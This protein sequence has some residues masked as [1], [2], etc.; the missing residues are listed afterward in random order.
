[1][2]A[3]SKLFTPSGRKFYVLFEEIADNINAVSRSF[4]ELTNTEGKDARKTLLDKIEQLEQD[5]DVVTHKLFVELGKNFI[6]PFDREDIH[7][8]ASALDDIADYV[9]GTA[10][11]MYYFEIHLINDTTT[12]LAH[13]ITE[14]S[15]LLKKAMIGLQNRRELT[16][17]T[18]ILS[19]M[20]GITSD[21]DIT[22]TNVTFNLFN[23][24]HNYI[25]IIK[26]NDHY[27]MLQDL[28]SKCAEVI[29][30]LE[31]M[32]IKYA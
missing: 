11:Q 2:N 19:E 20:R 18:E 25:D 32:V 31:G 22:I 16:A 3:L 21:G 24:D 7:Y 15:S 28:N 9:W 4:Y 1:M 17:L 14:F 23:E 8:M 5:N 30:V 12:Q 10:K 26:L 6:T 27:S 29:N 13:N